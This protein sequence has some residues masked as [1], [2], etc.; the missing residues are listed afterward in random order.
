MLCQQALIYSDDKN[1][2]EISDDAEDGLYFW[3]MLHRA[4]F[5]VIPLLLR[6]GWPQCACSPGPLCETLHRVVSASAKRKKIEDDEAFGKCL[7]M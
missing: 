1:R 2:F 3:G 6:T 5:S 7:G 4:P